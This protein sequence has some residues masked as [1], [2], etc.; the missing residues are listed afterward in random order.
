MRSKSNNGI[1]KKREKYP[2][3]GYPIFKSKIKYY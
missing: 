1:V 3:H 2:A